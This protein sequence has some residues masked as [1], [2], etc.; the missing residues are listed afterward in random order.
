[1]TTQ[2]ARIGASHKPRAAKR[3]VKKSMLGSPGVGGRSVRAA[4]RA[5]RFGTGR[6]EPK[7]QIAQKVLGRRRQVQA[8][9]GKSCMF[10]RHMQSDETLA[11]ARS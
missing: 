5:N 3:G 10:V 1:V 2:V 7:R 11:V 6:H 8:N 9:P 4:T